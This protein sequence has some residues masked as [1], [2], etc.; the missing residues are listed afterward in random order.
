MRCSQS[1]IQ[2]GWGAGGGRLVSAGRPPKNALL[3]AILREISAGFA[4]FC[5]CRLDFDSFCKKAQ[6]SGEISS[7]FSEKMTKNS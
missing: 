4:D 3:G 2:D 1:G 5:N 6:T 7:K